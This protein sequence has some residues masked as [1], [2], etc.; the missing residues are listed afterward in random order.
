MSAARQVGNGLWGEPIYTVPEI[1]APVGRLIDSLRLV[2]ARLETAQECYK[3]N[4]AAQKEWTG[5][6][7]VVDVGDNYI[8][9]SAA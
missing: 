7:S 6:V 9:G 4:L 3:A 5:P 8:G 2:I 1:T